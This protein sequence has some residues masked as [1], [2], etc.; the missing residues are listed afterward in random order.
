MSFRRGGLAPRA[1]ELSQRIL[2]NISHELKTPLFNMKERVFTPIEGGIED[3]Y[4]EYKYL[5]RIKISK[6]AGLYH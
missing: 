2:G 3:K 6:I 4:V 1:V 5:K